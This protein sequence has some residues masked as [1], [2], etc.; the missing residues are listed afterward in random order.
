VPGNLLVLALIAGFCFIHSCYRFKYRAQILDGYRLLF[1][2]SV[3][4]AIILA[5][6]RALVCFLKLFSLFWKYRP[7]WNSYGDVPYLGTFMLSIPVGIFSAM[8]WNLFV[9][10]EQGRESAVETDGDSLMSL[11][12]KALKEERMLSITLESRKWYAGY[13]VAAP[14]LRPSEKYFS[15]LP[16]L[17]GYRDKDTLE[18]RRTLR[19]DQVYE[20]IAGDGGISPEDFVI[21]LP[22]ASVRT[23]NLFDLAVYQDHFAGS[24][25][26]ALPV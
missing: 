18:A 5:V 23:A 25:D 13:L 8:V 4:G 11:M 9:T 16:V 2:C 21:T 6:S 1:H 19:Y 12:Q 15:L 7:L 3:A 17:S 10:H 24:G 20:R 26:D 22:L 14:D